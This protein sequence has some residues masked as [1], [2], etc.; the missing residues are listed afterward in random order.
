[1]GASIGRPL[2]LAVS[3]IA[4]TGVLASGGGGDTVA[5]LSGSGDS[6]ESFRLVHGSDVHLVFTVS[7]DGTVPCTPCM[8]CG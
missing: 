4:L 3:A 5:V 6:T 2:A 1:M 8:A 7:N